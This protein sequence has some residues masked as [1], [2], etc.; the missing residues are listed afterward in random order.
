MFEV[1]ED[2]AGGGG[3]RVVGGGRGV[4]LW[5]GPRRSRGRSP[6][7]TAAAARSVSAGVAFVTPRVTSATGYHSTAVITIAL[8]LL[9]GDKLKYLG[10]IF[11][12]TFATLLLAQQITIFLGLL[13]L[14]A[15]TVDTVRDADLWVMDPRV[16]YVDELEPLRDTDLF[17]VRSVEG[18]A[19]AV[20][21]FNGRATLKSPEIDQTYSVSVRGLDDATLTGA[22][23]EML[24]GDVASLREPDTIIFNQTGYNLIWPG[25]SLED[26]VGKVVEM[27]DR[28]VRVSG[29]CEVPSPFSSNTVVYASYSTAL[30]LVPG[31]R[32]R[33]SFVLARATDGTT[34]E[35][36]A[37]N[38]E[39]ATG[40]QALTRE[41]FSERSITY[42]IENTGIP[43]S[44]GAVIVMGGVVGIAVVSLTFYQF[45]TDN[46][47]QFA[48]LK[49]VGVTNGQILKM[50]FIQAGLIEVVGFGLGI[51]AAALFFF[52]GRNNP[53]LKYFIFRL[54]VVLAIFA[55]IT[56]IMLISIL[57]SIRRVL[58]LDPAVVFRG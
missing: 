38:I 42:I 14:A 43:A 26:A 8:K 16:D 22:P 56:V 53:D 28:R 24:V 6:N 39:A 49:A 33:M 55:A 15:S 2:R 10:C 58:V 11:G 50:V 21:L 34:T 13:G 3:G 19:W 9:T 25:E 57:T 32:N 23:E 27:N 51:G 48:A 20:P 54:D 45:V 47:R 30:D 7:M 52:S 31:Q 35:Q 5:L 18:V 36:A 46:L 12:V 44:F 37:A 4:S 40:L 29:I 1:L 17:R 41:Q